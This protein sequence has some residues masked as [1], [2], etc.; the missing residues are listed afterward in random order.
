MANTETFSSGGAS[1]GD[2]GPLL[3]AARDVASSVEALYRDAN[4][5]LAVQARDRPY[6]VL[7]T[8]AA[9]GF[10][11]A[12]GLASK[13]ARVAVA[14]GARWALSRTMSEALGGGSSSRGG[15]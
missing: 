14:L 11:V 3:D 4:A 13:T 9:I 6:A 7:G 15:P 2:G 1:S 5:A 12:G 10:V 8:A